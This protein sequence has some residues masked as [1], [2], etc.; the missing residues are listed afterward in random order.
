M[1]VAGSNLLSLVFCVTSFYQ[2]TVRPVSSGSDGEN[3]KGIVASN[4]CLRQK[5]KAPGE[6]DTGLEDSR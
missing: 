5:Q 3:R 2:I 6:D 4:V 1:S